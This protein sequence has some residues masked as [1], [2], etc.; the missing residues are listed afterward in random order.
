MPRYYCHEKYFQSIY[1]SSQ[2]THLPSANDPMLPYPSADASSM[3]ALNMRE[4]CT[5]SVPILRAMPLGLRKSR[6]SRPGVNRRRSHDVTGWDENVTYQYK[7]D[8]W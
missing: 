7:E 2:F 6:W 8:T 3:Q 4:V 1:V 5:L